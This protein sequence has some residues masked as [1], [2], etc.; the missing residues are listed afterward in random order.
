MPE[1]VKELP[2]GIAV[3]S[4]PVGAE[5]VTVSVAVNGKAYSEEVEARTLLVD[6]LRE[7]LANFLFMTYPP[8]HFA[9][10][11]LSW[12]LGSNIISSAL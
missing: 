2:I 7:T 12:T 1:K 8:P 3:N 9:P 6:F 10:K 11:W 5:R 4:K